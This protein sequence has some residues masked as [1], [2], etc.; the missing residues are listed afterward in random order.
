MP[1]D[2]FSVPPCDVLVADDQLFHRDMVTEML[3]AKGLRVSSVGSGHEAVAAYLKFE[4]KPVVLMDN[5]MP[6]M[7]GIEAARAIKSFDPNARIIFVSS[8]VGNR[9]EA[10]AAGALGFV[11]KPFKIADVFAAVS[12][13]RTYKF[14]EQAQAGASA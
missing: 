10:I 11:T 13:A 1:S 4:E 12:W 5:V 2:D 14:P 9:E 8:D 6:T 7:T 3:R